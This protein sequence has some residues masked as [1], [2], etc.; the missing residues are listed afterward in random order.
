MVLEKRTEKSSFEATKNDQLWF[1]EIL[2]VFGVK[3]KVKM[4]AAE[5]SPPAVP[6]RS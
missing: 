3:I 1:G 4:D 5:V 2:F 6:H